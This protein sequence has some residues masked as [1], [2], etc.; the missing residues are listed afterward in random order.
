MLRFMGSQRVGHN[1]A[2]ELN[3]WSFYRFLK[4]FGF[5]F[6]RWASLVAQMVKF[7]YSAE[8]PGLI[9][10]SGRSRGE[11]NGNSLQY[12]CLENPMDRGA[13]LATVH[14]VTK[15]QTRLS[16]FLV[17]FLLLTIIL[18]F[19]L[20]FFCFLAFPC[21]LPREVTLAFVV[22]LVWWCWIL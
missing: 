7:A 4:C 21:F 11:G 22:K 19:F 8:D 6:C 5:I 13:W 15:C 18:S 1:P 17:F 2:T 14:G 20:S 12:S 10:G 9:P 16:N 3:W